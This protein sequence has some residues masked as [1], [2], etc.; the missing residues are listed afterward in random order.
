MA[1]LLIRARST[2]HSDVQKDRMCYKRGMPVV[3][4]PNGHVWG[5][6]ERL[7]GFV[8]LRIS[9]TTVAQLQRL[10]DPNLDDDLSA[11]LGQDVVLRRRRYRFNL[12]SLPAAVRDELLATGMVTASWTQVRDYV[13]DDKDGS[14]LTNRALP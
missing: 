12:D 3:A 11:L 4:M 9:G 2:T 14:T 13:T 5:S 6:E 1:E 8:V 10:L 7:P